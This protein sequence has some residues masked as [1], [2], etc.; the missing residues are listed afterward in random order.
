[1]SEAQATSS[2]GPFVR[3]AAA[4]FGKTPVKYCSPSERMGTKSRFPQ[5][6]HLSIS[7]YLACEVCETATSRCAGRTPAACGVRATA[8]MADFEQWPCQS[9]HVHDP[10]QQAKAFLRRA[11]GSTAPL[12]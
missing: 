3:G 12:E 1:M 2:S 11:R 10:A 4:A 8:G 5:I 9:G 6:R 7:R